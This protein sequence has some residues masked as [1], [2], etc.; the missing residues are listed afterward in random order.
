MGVP[1]FQMTRL[2]RLINRSRQPVVTMILQL[3]INNI[4]MP[5]MSARNLWQHKQLWDRMLEIRSLVGKFHKL[6]EAESFLR[7]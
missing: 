5:A 4:D 3:A 6:H 2:S 1:V 7:S